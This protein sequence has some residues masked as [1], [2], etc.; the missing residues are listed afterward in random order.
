MHL[1]ETKEKNKQSIV[2]KLFSYLSWVGV[3]AFV[4]GVIPPVFFKGGFGV[5]LVINPIFL[6]LATIFSFIVRKEKQIRWKI[7]FATNLSFF[8]LYVAS[9]IFILL[10]L[11]AIVG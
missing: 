9:F 8:L 1:D 3:L 11:G 4:V 7:S 6:F 5:F 10:A 2:L